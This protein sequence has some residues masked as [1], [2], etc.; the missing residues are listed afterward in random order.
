M[1][2]RRP[3]GVIHHLYHLKESRY[4]S[5]AFGRRCTEVRLRP[6]EAVPAARTARKRELGVSV[7][8]AVIR[9]GNKC[10][11]ALKP[12]PVAYALGRSEGQAR[13]L[14]D[15]EEALSDHGVSIG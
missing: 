12:C 8:L 10:P 7:R 2:T 1:P 11:N 6:S 3:N 13:H 9:N 4:M 5:C 14:S 15:T